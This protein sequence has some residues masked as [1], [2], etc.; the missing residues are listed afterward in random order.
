MPLP[1]IR[2]WQEPQPVTPS[3]ALVQLAGS[4]LAAEMLCRR[5]LGEI[6]AAEK[7]LFTDKYTPTSPFD[8]PG[9][10]EAVACL[11]QAASTAQPICVWGDFDVDGQTSTTILVSALRRLGA[12]VSYFIP[13]RAKHS[14]GVHLEPLREL[15]AA[16]VK[17]LLTCDTGISAG[18][19]IAWA[20]AQGVKVVVTDH[21]EL[22]AVLPEAEAVVNPRMLAADNP[23]ATLPG[24]GVA[25]ILAQALLSRQEVEDLLDLVALGLVADAAEL[26][27]EA[28]YLL[29]IGLE[30]IRSTT[31]LGLTQLF[32]RAGVNQATINEETISF[33]L[34]PRLNALG[35]LADANGIVDFFTASSAAQAAFFAERLEGLNT[36]RVQAVRQ[37][38]LSAEEMIQRTPGLLDLPALVLSN[39]AWEAG[40][41]GIVA[42]RLVER[43]NRPAILFREQAGEAAGSARSVKGIHITQAIAAHAEILHRFGGHPMAAGLSLPTDLIPDFRQA[44]AYTLRE[45]PGG[46]PTNP[47]LLDAEVPLADITLQNIHNLEALSPFGVGNPAPVFFNRDLRTRSEKPLGREGEHTLYVVED[48]DGLTHEVVRWHSTGQRAP[49]ALFDLAYTPRRSTFRGEMKLQLEWVDS[50]PAA[51]AESGKSR[52]TLK[53]EDWRD[54]DLLSARVVAAGEADAQIWCE[55][56]AATGMVD[57]ASLLPAG[58]LFIAFVPPGPAEIAAVLR[59]VKPRR[60]VLLP[61]SPADDGVQ[62][63]IKQL[64]TA[65]KPHLSAG[66]P[67]VSVE[68]LAARLGHL[69]RT[70]DTGLQFLEASGLLQRT[71]TGDGSLM[72]GQPVTAA[73]DLDR[74]AQLEVNLIRLLK[75]TARFRAYFAAAALDQLRTDFF[76]L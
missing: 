38:L 9:M 22:P 31:R 72:L 16:G 40:V 33:A 36:R 63:F 42:A 25:Y 28:R 20:R 10:A 62:A 14:H 24:C 18:E 43:Y 3:E 71:P 13:V 35:R 7:F 45:L 66:K 8:L 17:V 55:P 68:A 39:P 32:L 57:R 67:P 50:R 37:I 59:A 60:V 26:R 27:G 23:L 30:A 34:A 11:K 65:V 58:T 74:K 19:E 41:L 73:V 64:M 61:A 69:T 46:L 51:R 49:D 4:R 47:L 1:V 44:L 56:P 53:V 29:Q 76:M 5:N 75:E 70:V 6:A 21:H 54:R 12:R 15:V 2:P 48:R 52:P